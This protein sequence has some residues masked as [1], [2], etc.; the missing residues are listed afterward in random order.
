VRTH[1]NCPLSLSATEGA[2]QEDEEGDPR[3]HA[4]QDL[5][6]GQRRQGLTR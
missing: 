4:Q 2:L 6:C 3:G 5:C 1:S